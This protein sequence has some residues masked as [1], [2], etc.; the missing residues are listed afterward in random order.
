MACPGAVSVIDLT[1]TDSEVSDSASDIDA[2][3]I[4]N[5]R[6]DECAIEQHGKY[7]R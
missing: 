3:I 6:L 2:A 1:A 7:Y 5:G 4:R